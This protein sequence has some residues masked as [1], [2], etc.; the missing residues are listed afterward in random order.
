MKFKNI[1]KKETSSGALD[2][3]HHMASRRN[4]MIS[5]SLAMG[6]VQLRSLITGLPVPFLLGASQ[7]VVAAQADKKFV[8]I[9]HVQEGDPIN[10]NAPG[11]YADD[12]S[13]GNDPLNRI[14]HPD[15]QGFKTP[16]SFK[17]GQVNVKAAQP[18]STLDE[19]LRE[20]MGFWHHGTYTNAHPEFPSVRRLN[21]LAKKSDGS[22]S[23]EISEILASENYKGLGTLIAEPITLGGSQVEYKNRTLPL[24]TPV[25]LKKLFSGDGNANTIDRMVALRDTFMDE[26]YKNLVKSGTPA[27]KKFFDSYALSQQTARKIGDNL[28][29]R[30]E[31]IS[32]NLEASQ[33]LLAAA[34]ISLKVCPVIT[35]GLNF[36]GDNHADKILNDE[37]SQ[38]R[39]VMPAINSLWQELGRL[40]IQ[41]QTVIANLNT[42]GRSLLRNQPGGR[43]HNGGHHTM[44][45]IGANVRPGVIGGVEENKK[46]FQARPIDSVS[47]K[48]SVSADIPHEDTL[49]SVAKTLAASAGIERDV[50]AKRFNGGKI[51]EAALNI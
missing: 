49:V 13:N 1:V 28:A 8:I 23:V 10:T 30:L 26:A 29:E 4:L 19:D 11:S 44:F 21:G 24:L 47:G 37:V 43:N 33:G 16:T 32:D 25:D 3:S 48:P 35:M 46:D 20:R 50:I 2:T 42:F 40:G 5:A 12:P 45:V 17:L 22:G 39:A 34:L 41:D 27:Q 9:S 15:V 51:I 14:Q 7:A 18:W 38:T 31:K 6:S 36:G